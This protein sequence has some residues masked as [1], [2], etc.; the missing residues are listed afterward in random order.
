MAKLVYIQIKAFN[1]VTAT[2]SK[3]YRHVGFTMVDNVL[4]FLHALK[5][6]KVCG[7]MFL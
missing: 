7:L 1:P 3:P 4:I 2:F 5:S 6:L